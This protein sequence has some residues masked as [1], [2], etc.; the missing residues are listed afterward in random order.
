MSIPCSQRRSGSLLLSN[1]HDLEGQIVRHAADEVLH[2]RMIL[3]I[4]DDMRVVGILSVRLQC[5]AGALQRFQ[6]PASCQH[7]PTSQMK[8]KN[9]PEADGLILTASN[10]ASFLMCTPVQTKALCLMANQLHLRRRCAG[11]G[12]AMLGSVKD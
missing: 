9:A 6:I 12:E 7:S 3:H 5:L 2:E 1:I 4:I 8:L 11:R 10:K